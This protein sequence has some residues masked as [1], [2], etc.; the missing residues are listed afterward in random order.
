MLQCCSAN[1]GASH[2]QPPAC[3]Q[4]FIGWADAGT[5]VYPR[6]AGFPFGLGETK[7]ILLEMHYENIARTKGI[8]DTSGLEFTCVRRA[9]TRALH[10]HR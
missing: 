8:V 1:C 3:P 7:S 10:E 2:A 4:N 9:A 6:E 5:I